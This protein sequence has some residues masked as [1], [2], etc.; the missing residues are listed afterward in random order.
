MEELAITSYTLFGE[1][2]D[3]VWG[4]DHDPIQKTGWFLSNIY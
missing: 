4:E 2:L 1:T 3:I